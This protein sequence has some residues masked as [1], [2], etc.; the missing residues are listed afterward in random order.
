MQVCAVSVAYN[1]PRELARL[2]CSLET[3]SRL[4]G[5]IVLDNSR[6]AYL[7]E[8]EAAF[9][10]YAERYAFAKY[11]RSK[12]NRGSA[13]G[14]RLG[15]KIA[16]EQ[17]FDWV[18]LLDQD[19]TVQN[20]CLSSLLQNCDRGDILCP[21]IV[22]IDDP[23]VVLAQSGA[24]QNFWGRIVWNAS[25]VSQDISFFGTHGALISK[26]ALD[27]VGYYD[28][29]NFFV[30]AE[31][32]DYAFRTTS[33]HLAIRLVAEAQARHRDARHKSAEK[34]DRLIDD[35]VIDSISA[36]GGA[37]GFKRFSYRGLTRLEP[38]TS[39]PFERILPEH[40]GYVSSKIVN[41]QNCRENQGLTSLSFAYL[42]TKRLTTLQLATACFYSVCTTLL[43]KVVSNGR[44]SLKETL[45]M[46]WV[47][48]LSK[49]RKEWPFESVEQFC[50]RLCK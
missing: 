13:G 14:F 26:K 5:L 10:M 9:R 11:I 20:G 35:G 1:N 15:M 27:V 32:L 2:L 7:K 3:Q 18:W 30:G 49:I 19:G 50:R 42:A 12:V 37:A 31:D 23:S 6:E 8:N 33:K 41:N 40:L 43:R 4:N 16:H 25:T 17:E 46:Y 36:E 45:T 44:I 28:Q 29:S 21:Q 47:C 38:M 22:D 39:G 48:L 34:K 24:V